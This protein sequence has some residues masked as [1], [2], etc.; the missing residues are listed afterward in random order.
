MVNF[1]LKFV[2]CIWILIYDC[3]IFFFLV[4]NCGEDKKKK[5]VKGVQASISKLATKNVFRNETEWGTLANAVATAT[6]HNR[7]K[8]IILLRELLQP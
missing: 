8:I 6:S 3:K 2:T 5:G 7:D 4:L 1:H